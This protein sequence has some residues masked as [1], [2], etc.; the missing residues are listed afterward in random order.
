MAKVATTAEGCDASTD[1]PATVTRQRQQAG[2]IAKFCYWGHGVTWH[3]EKFI[4]KSPTGN[5]VCNNCDT[6]F[7]PAGDKVE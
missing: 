4:T 7:T 1:A 2:R 5:N 6:E 3:P